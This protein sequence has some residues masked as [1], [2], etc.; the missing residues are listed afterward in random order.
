MRASQSQSIPVTHNG[1]VVGMVREEQL[2]AQPVT[3]REQELVVSDVMDTN[4]PCANIYMTV[5][6][7][8][9]LMMRAQAEALPV[10]DEFGSY[11]GIITRSDVLA[12]RMEVV[13][14]P[15]I[16][17]MATPIGVHL[18]TGAISAGAGSLGLYLSGVA[19]MLMLVAARAILLALAFASD[20]LF[21]THL[22]PLIASPATGVFNGE[23]MQLDSAP[24]LFT[25][26][27]VVL[28]M[29]LL[30]LSPLSGYHAAEHQ[31]VHTIEAGE[32]LTP[33]NVMRMPRAHPRCGT[34]LMAGAALFMAIAGN[35][36]T[37]LGGSIGILVGLI[38]VV[39][40]WRTVGY[41]LQQFV[42]TK[43]PAPW[44][45]K[46]GIKAGEELLD[47]YR[48]EPGKSAYGWARI[49]NVGIIQVALGFITVLLLLQAAQGILPGLTGSG[50]W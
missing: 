4:P 33:E 19:M 10:I 32:L 12:S 8:A 7:T 14:P 50:L 18:T 16:A 9:E 37:G 21:S 42:T 44:H 27:Q 25:L 28:M 48:R 24:Y 35:L 15:T 11:R 47:K 31:V 49:W 1:R 3:G 20:R 22:L 6:Q 17:G 23:A 45:V 46:A 38:V 34:N 39:I 13:N 5:G 36:G 41:Y 26:L 29:V 40:G 2:L 43:P 30:R